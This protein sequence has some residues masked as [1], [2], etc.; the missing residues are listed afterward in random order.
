M[1]NTTIIGKATIHNMDCMEL[2][3]ATPDKFYDLAIVDPPY[4]IG[5]WTTGKS[6][7]FVNGNK[8]VTKNGKF[9]DVKWNDEIPNP[10]Y[11]EET[12]RVSK[13]QIIWGANYYNCFDKL[14]GSIIWHKGSI[15]PVFSQCEIASLSFQ[16]RVD[17]VHIDWQAGFARKKEG[18]TI[19]PCQKPVKLYEWLLTNYAKQGDKI[20]DTHL[21]S[22]SSV[23]ACLN[24]GYEITGCELD[25]DYFDAGIKRVEQSQK[26]QRMF[27]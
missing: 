17:Y 13:R 8:V 10:I 9:K 7:N 3:K 16:K 2:L 15:N 12:I 11:F 18:E 22:M 24:L 4:G 20:L 6:V 14:G 23:I 25:K 5:D 21:G 1:K 26:Q 27:A 19:H